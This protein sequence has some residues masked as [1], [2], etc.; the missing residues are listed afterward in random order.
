MG[1][2]MYSTHRFQSLKVPI[3][4]K[5]MKMD[6]LFI[7]KPCYCSILDTILITFSKSFSRVSADL[8]TTP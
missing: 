1:A 6:K 5:E 3:L 8:N 4:Q 2:K 7:G